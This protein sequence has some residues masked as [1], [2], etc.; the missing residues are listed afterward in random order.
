MAI[1]YVPAGVLDEASRGQYVQRMHAAF[2]EA[3]PA[4]EKRQLATSVVLHDVPNGTWGASGALWKLADF[5]KVSGYA[6]LQHLVRA[7]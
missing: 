5:A 1:V 3:M 2:K 7:A 4:S 6:H